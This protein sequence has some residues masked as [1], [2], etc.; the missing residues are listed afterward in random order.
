MIHILEGS[1][2]NLLKQLPSNSIDSCITSPPYWQLRDYKVEDQIGREKDP[3]EYI[4]KLVEIFNE[5]NRILKKTGTLWLNIGDTYAG[6]NKATGKVWRDS[7]ESG[8][9]PKHSKF[10][11]K[12]EG[13]IV[14]E[15]TPV[16]KG[17][18]RKDL[19]GIPWMLAFALR[20]NGWYLRQDIIWHKPSPMPESV[21][22][23]CTRAHEY[24][25]LMSKS[26][27]YY[28]NQQ[29]IKEKS[30]HKESIE[31]RGY[32]RADEVANDPGFEIR[33]GF[34]NIPVGKTYPV[35]NKRSVWKVAQVSYPGAHF[36]TYPPKLIEPMILAG[37]PEGGTIIDPFGG[38][39]TT[40]VVADRLNRNCISIDVS[41][42]Y[43]E[44]QYQ[45]IM[46]ELGLFVMD[47]ENYV[48]KSKGVPSCLLGKTENGSVM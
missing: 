4:K 1:S 47:T 29:A 30:I 33:A 17:M 32:R 10:Q 24:V 41:D 14:T 27:K 36:A 8:E 3:E 42:K 21:E 37:C 22:D 7:E 45:R 2:L 13:S 12:N 19:V 11:T 15:R 23:R 20:A 44:M 25:F 26:P 39:G 48:L 35:R 34:Q 9:S 31:G 43:C 46:N 5:V 6:G 28:Y 38:A 18:K 40:A 16:P